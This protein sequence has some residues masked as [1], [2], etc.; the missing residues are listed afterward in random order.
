[1][2]NNLEQ[3]V[4]KIEERNRAVETD[5]GW[6]TSWTRRGLLTLFT[7]LAIGVYMWA[8]DIA[9]PWLNAIVPA[10][11]F[12]LSTLTMPWFKKMWLRYRSKVKK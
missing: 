2:G 3:R 12:V 11:A 10:V 9:R 6:E 8:V 1:M 4:Q 5:K 7:Y